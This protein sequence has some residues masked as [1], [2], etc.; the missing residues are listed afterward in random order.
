MTIA[1]NDLLPALLEGAPTPGLPTGVAEPATTR[2][3]PE[4]EPVRDVL[5]IDQ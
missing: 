1:P 5:K 3:V 4:T 2:L